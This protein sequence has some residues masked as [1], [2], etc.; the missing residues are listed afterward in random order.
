MCLAQGPQR[1]DAGEARTRGLSVSSQSLYHWATALPHLTFLSKFSFQLTAR[2]RGSRK[3]CQRGVQLNLTFCQPFFLINWWGER[4]SN[5]TK[6]RTIID[7]PA[8]RHLKADRW[9]PNNIEFYNLTGIQIRP[10]GYKTFFFMLNSTEHEISTAHKS[11]NTDKW[12]SFLLQV[13][14]IMYLSC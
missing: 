2:I 4:E 6:K 10:Q 3:F 7:P 5:T 11:L 9:W 12:R 14:E 8:K 1:S 13:S